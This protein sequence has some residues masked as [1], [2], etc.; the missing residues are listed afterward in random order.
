MFNSKY[1]RNVDR[2]TIVTPMF[3]YKIVHRMQLNSCVCE[4]D[5]TFLMP[6]ARLYPIKSKLVQFFERKSK[7]LRHTGKSYAKP[8]WAKMAQ[9]NEC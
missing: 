4:F 2:I 1:M 6:D 5:N 9:D 3:S 7:Q 8:A